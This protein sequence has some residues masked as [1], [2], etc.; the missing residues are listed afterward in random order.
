MRKVTD[1]AHANAQENIALPAFVPYP[2]AP[3]H[4]VGQA[5]AGLF[6]A[7]RTESLPPGLTPL[8][9]AGWRVVALVRYLEGSDLCYDEVIVGALARVGWRVGL[10]V[11]TI[12]VDS[13]SS[14]WGGR[15]IWGLP[16]TLATFTW[17][18]DHCRITDSEGLMM[19]LRVNRHNGWLPSLLLAAVGIGRL[20]ERWAML[21]APGRAR[22]IQAGLHI[23]EWSARFPYTL[24]HK[25]LI[26]CAANPFHVMFPP[27]KIVGSKH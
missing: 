18:G 23:E 4:A 6:R 12:A 5:W 8:I 15:R 16:K 21:T 13:A 17:E 14:L 24:A 1:E 9:G 25:P 3:W 27:P 20:D 19:T 10:Y 11:E 26:A 7:N 2:P 22:L